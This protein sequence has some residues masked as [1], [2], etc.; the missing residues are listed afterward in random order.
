MLRVKIFF[1]VVFLGFGC[2]YALKIAIPTLPKAL[3][4]SI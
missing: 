3:V 4:S 2:Q 1:A